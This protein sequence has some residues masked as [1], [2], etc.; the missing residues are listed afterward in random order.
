[1]TVNSYGVGQVIA[2]ALDDDTV[3]KIILS[4]GHAGTTDAGAGM[5]EALGY[6]LLD[7]EGR[8]VI[9]NVRSPLEKACRAAALERLTRI[10]G[11]ARHPGL[12]PCTFVATSP[13]Q[14]FSV[15]LTACIMFPS[16]T[17]EIRG[18]VRD[19]VVLL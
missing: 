13:S 1:M 10:D 5:L 9:I 11:S 7:A 18:R 8:R 6:R 14:V 3:T 15:L 2:A 16:E 4:C 17:S 19:G 12:D